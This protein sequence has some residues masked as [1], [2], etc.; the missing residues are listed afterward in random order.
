MLHFST[1]FKLHTLILYNESRGWQYEADNNSPSE[2]QLVPYCQS[3]LSASFSS[4]DGWYSCS[5]SWDDCSP[6]CSRRHNDFKK[7]NPSRGKCTFN[8]SMKSDKNTAE[9]HRV[10]RLPS[11]WSTILLTYSYTVPFTS[12]WNK[13]IIQVLPHTGDFSQNVPLKTTVKQSWETTWCV[14]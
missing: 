7:N 5:E 8:W 13:K 3:I 14:I 1:Y 6:S 12:Q 10:R 9:H 11:H 4:T 2:A